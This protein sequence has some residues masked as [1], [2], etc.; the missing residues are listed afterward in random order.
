[1]ENYLGIERRKENIFMQERIA[2]LEEKTNKV[3]KN[4]DELSNE[5][6]TS[7][8]SIISF[9][10]KIPE[11]VRVIENLTQ[12]LKE[13]K[14]TLTEE[15]DANKKDAE[16][17]REECRGINTRLSI[18]EK[19]FGEDKDKIQDLMRKSW[20]LG[21][22]GGI[23]GGLIGKITPELGKIIVTFLS[24]VILGI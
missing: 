3:E 22:L 16:S 10:N 5:F 17:H 7:R 15:I 13:H 18:I 2:V 23:I 1:M 8:D 24:K 21:V 14:T 20:R 11:L 6:K 4:I 19:S 9:S 12:E